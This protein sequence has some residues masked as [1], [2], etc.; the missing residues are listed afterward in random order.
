M[1]VKKMKQCELCEF[2]DKEYDELL[3]SGDDV[4]I[5]GQEDKE[6]HYCPM[7]DMAVVADDIINDKAKCKY[8]VLRLDSQKIK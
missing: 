6:N 5:V 4:I 8:F 2:Y 3:Q 1:S 7:Y